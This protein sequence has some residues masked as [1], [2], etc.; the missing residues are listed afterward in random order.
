VSDNSKTGWGMLLA[1]DTDQPEFARGFEA[2]RIW[3]LLGAEDLELPTDP[4]MLHAANAEMVLRIA[5]SRG[6]SA[7]SKEI[8]DDWIEV[9][10]DCASSGGSGAG[11]GDT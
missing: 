2:G 3:E 7:Q 8:G 5:E 10:F 6:L 11:G 4:V 1:F 9:T